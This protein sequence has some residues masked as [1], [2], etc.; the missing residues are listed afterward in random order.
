[1]EKIG[2]V[3][4]NLIHHEE[5]LFFIGEPVKGKIALIPKQDL[6]IEQVGY[7]LILES[8]GKINTTT[9]ILLGKSLMRD[10]T[11]LK[12]KEYFFDINFTNKRIETYKGVNTSFISQ[13]EFFIRLK[14]QLIDQN[15]SNIFSKIVRVFQHNK[16]F[17]KSL[18]LEFKSKNNSYSVHASDGELSVEYQSSYIFFTFALIVLFLILTINSTISIYP[19]IMIGALLLGILCLYLSYTLLIGILLIQ[20]ENLGQ[21]KLT[22][23]ISNK[24]RWKAVNL[25]WAHY[26]VLEEALDRRGTSNVSVTERL[27]ISKESLIKNPTG[28]ASFEFDFPKDIMATTTIGDSKIYWLA[29]IKVKTSLGISY[30]H[31][32]EFIVKKT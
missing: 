17:T 8:R 10:R 16:N 20:Y 5:N 1:M 22:F 23:K 12:D 29:I 21:N 13:F 19:S 14:D 7:N 27:F 30:T 24:K 6:P 9:E 15:K 28:T 3:N 4:I 11:L 18:Y 25:I 26:E 32:Q 31:T 2:N